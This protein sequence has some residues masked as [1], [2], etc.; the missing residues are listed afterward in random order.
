M[1]ISSSFVSRFGTHSLKSRGATKAGNSMIDPHLLDR[2][3]GWKCKK[4][5]HRYIGVR[6]DRLLTVS[7]SLN[8]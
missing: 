5:K 1:K 4:T 2:H 3:A 7:D 6:R 8:L